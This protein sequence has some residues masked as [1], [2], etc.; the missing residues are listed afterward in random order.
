MAITK[1]AGGF[2]LDV[3]HRGRR[4]R[5]TLKGGTHFDAQRKELEVVQSFVEHGCWPPPKVTDE[6]QRLAG[7][8]VKLDLDAAYER[9]RTVG[10]KGVRRST[11]WAAGA[12]YHS[13]VTDINYQRDIRPFFMGDDERGIRPQPSRGVLSA[14]TESEV[15]AFR[16]WLRTRQPRL[17]PSTVNSKL[18]TLSMI[19]R[20]AMQSPPLVEHPMPLP[21]RVEGGRRRERVLSEEEERECFDFYGRS[22][23]PEDRDMRDIVMFG[24]YGGLIFSEIFRLTW[25]DFE[26]PRDG[27]PATMRVNLSAYED[28]KTKDRK[29]TLMIPRKL[30]EVALRRSR[31]A[32]LRGDRKLFVGWDKHKG[33]RAWNR[34][35]DYMGQMHNDDFVFYMLRHTCATRLADRT[36]DPLV[37]KEYMR[38]GSLTTTMRYIHT[39]PRMRAA[40]ARAFDDADG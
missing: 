6:A 40:A 14:I 2:R 5:L 1:V 3:K 16:A 8:G 19:L 11:P 23:S 15:A 25:P 30:A 21:E 31:D 34:Y 9:C 12:S 29:K 32:R 24:L 20:A 37:V 18:S 22:V 36:G 27:S 28:G 10:V 35:R 7:R 26:F 39:T 38:H 4:A 17:A 13:T 33:V